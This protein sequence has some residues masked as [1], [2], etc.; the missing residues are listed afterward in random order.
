M[1]T[2]LKKGGGKPATRRPQKEAAAPKNPRHPKR[3]ELRGT[4]E[5]LREDGGPFAGALCKG[6]NHRTEGC[7]EN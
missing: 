6:A 4:C 1:G 3:I 2:G 7:I 5:P